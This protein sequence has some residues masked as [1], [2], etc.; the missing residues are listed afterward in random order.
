MTELAQEEWQHEQYEKLFGFNIYEA[1][2]AVVLGVDYHDVDLFIKE[3][4]SCSPQM[5][6]RILA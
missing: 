5:A 1:T 2:E 6:V 3:H 4:A